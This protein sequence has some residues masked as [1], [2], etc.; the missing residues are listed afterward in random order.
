MPLPKIRC[1]DIDYR[2][3]FV[4]ILPGIHPGHVNLEVWNVRSDVPLATFDWGD[5][6]LDDCYTNNVEL[7]L[8]LDEA[9]A[10]AGR[11]QSAIAAVERAGMV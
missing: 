3:G 6:A 5:P 8:S 10:M 9:R 11:L 4:E 7:E 2:Q 1:C